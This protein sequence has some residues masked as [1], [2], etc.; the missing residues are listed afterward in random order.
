MKVIVLIED[1]WTGH[2]PTYLKL[3]NKTLLEL[4]HQVIT[5]C[6][7]PH[8]LESWIKTHCQPKAEQ[9]QVFEF[10]K[11][12][13]TRSPLQQLHPILNSVNLWRNA[14][15]SVDR[16]FHK[17][18]RIPDLVF[19]CVLDGYLVT[20]LTQHL[21]DQIFPYPWSGLYFHP[22]HMRLAPKFWSVFPAFAQPHAGL[23]S[24]HCLAIALLDEGITDRFKSSFFGKTIL[25]FPDCTDASE[26]DLSF[27]L[28]QEIKEKA[29]GRKI[30]GLLGS[31]SRRKGI[32]K[33]VEVA[34]KMASEN[35]FFVFAGKLY[36]KTFSKKEHTKLLEII[37]SNLNNCFF[38]WNVIPDGSRFNGL[39]SLCDIL[40][41][42]YD[43]FPHSS[44][45]LNKAATFAKPIIVSNGYCMA[46][47]V[48][49]F[50][51]GVS[52]HE[53]SVEECIEAIHFL[54]STP[55]NK[56]NFQGYLNAHAIDKLSPAFQ[57]IL[58][59]LE[60]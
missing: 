48:E 38:Y 4:G 15:V 23:Y 56:P 36:P 59:C 3:F 49:K 34:N 26:P 13:S 11:P 29:Q 46:E 27:P 22:R 9:Y 24:A 20:G 28:I 6:P 45:T 1:S 43:R 12:A 37:G 33:L 31:Q 50:N 44:N 17:L 21:I 53:D 47:R 40:F 5:F 16:A 25:N 10:R 41:A 39:V 60:S 54:D 55:L 30:I 14:K 35:F 51:L 18:G 32:F 8:E 52:I 57:G 7:E 2:R 19:F 58:D 42:A